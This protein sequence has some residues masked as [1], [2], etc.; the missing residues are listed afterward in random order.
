MTDK[1]GI[2]FTTQKFAFGQR[3]GLRTDTTST[4]A[5]LGA[6]DSLTKV[7][8]DL[9]SILGALFGPTA[10]TATWGYDPAVQWLVGVEINYSIVSFD[11]LLIDG[12]FYGM[13]IKIGPKPK[14]PPNGK[15]GKKNGDNGENGNGNGENGNG[16]NGNGNGNGPKPDDDPFGGLELEILYRK[17][18]DHLG[19]YSADL[20]LPKKYRTIKLEAASLTLPSVGLAIWTNGD[21]KVSIG[22]PLGDRSLSIIFPPDPIPWAGGGGLYFAKLRSEDAPGL[23]TDFGT[24][25]EFGIALRIGAATQGDWGIVKY[26][27]SIYLFGTFQGMLAWREGKTINEGIDYYWFAATVGLQGSLSAEVDFKIITI[28]LS[29]TL[30]ASAGLALETEHKST[31]EFEFKVTVEAS[32]KILFFRIKLSY[33]LDLKKDITFGSG[34]TAALLTGPTPPTQVVPAPPVLAEFAARPA[35][36]A[37]PSAIPIPPV[38]VNAQLVLQPTI[39]YDTASSTWKS[40]AVA[41]LVVERPD[42]GGSDEFSPLVGSLVT[43]L[44]TTY[45]GY[46]D[47]TQPLQP[48]QL[49]AVGKALDAG[50]FDL[51]AIYAWLATVQFTIAG[52]TSATG[53][54]VAAAVLPMIPG[55][56]LTYGGTTTT[57]GDATEPPEYAQ[58]L[59]DYFAQLSMVGDGSIAQAA[60]ATAPAP[61]VT[62]FPGVIFHD[63]FNMLGKQAAQE[64]HEAA[65]KAPVPLAQ[66]LAGLDVANLAGVVTRFLQHGLRVPD[67]AS[68]SGPLDQMPTRGLYELT[69]QQF[70]LVDDGTGNKILT[71]TIAAASPSVAV[72]VTAGE[73]ALLFALSNPPEASPLLSPQPLEPIQYV[74]SFAMLRQGYSWADQSTTWALYDFPEMLQADLRLRSPLL[75]DL[76]TIDENNQTAPIAGVEGLMIRFSLAPVPQAPGEPPPSMPVFQVA[77][78]DD[79]T[80]DLIDCCSPR[81]TSRRHSST[82]CSRAPR[83]GLT[84]RQPRT[85]RRRS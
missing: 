33:T 58:V 40:A 44:A 85:P 18:A 31:A 25:I 69:G 71:A 35:L 11:V 12:E 42:S 15:N 41:S 73:A 51:P 27:A 47:P 21:F 48:E 60:L 55:L 37:A 52:A 49:D 24:I 1:G 38:T 10:P 29:L 63:Y 23:G 76:T 19:E 67:P 53:A 75:L 30:M 36:A 77:G 17:V 46:T 43:Y 61:A 7:P 45:G 65:V 22:W 83:P 59:T 54:E 74:P 4:Q 82:S 3:I 78:T 9:T 2:S 81:A 72:T 80:R 6:L 28:S 68:A 70:D 5:I 16:E 20:T 14:P 79:A 39:R 57:F 32:V 50:T 8:G 66:A 84:R 26:S 13:R 34:A 56:A 62:W 64:L